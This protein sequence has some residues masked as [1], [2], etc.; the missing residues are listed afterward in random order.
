M[1]F[2]GYMTEM[3][4][5]CVGLI[6]DCTA[7]GFV[8]APCTGGRLSNQLS[9]TD[10]LALFDE[11]SSCRETKKLALSLESSATNRPKQLHHKYR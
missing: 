1:I 7:L 5:V 9:A 6:C 3:S 8:A 2:D 11:E 10:Q 4:R